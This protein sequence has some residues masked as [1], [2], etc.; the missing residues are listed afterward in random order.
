MCVWL[1]TFPL[2][3]EQFQGQRHFF[4]QATESATLA[5][6]TLINVS[7]LHPLYRSWMLQASRH[8]RWKESMWHRCHEFVSLFAIY[9]NSLSLAIFENIATIIIIAL[10][11]SSSHQSQPISFLVG[12]RRIWQLCRRIFVTSLAAI[13]LYDAHVS[14]KEPYNEKNA[15]L[16]SL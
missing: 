11:E 13:Y 3:S 16:R 10:G 14:P 9:N 7:A 2:R 1:V 5:E 12:V 6:A 15:K 8:G 4:E